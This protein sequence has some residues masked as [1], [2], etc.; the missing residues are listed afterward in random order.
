MPSRR[1][2][3]D[4]EAPSEDAYREASGEDENKGKGKG[5]HKRG[6]RRGGR[7]V[8]DRQFALQ[9]S[10]PP[11]IGSDSILVNRRA[12][13]AANLTTIAAGPTLSKVAAV[14]GKWR[15]VHRE[16][17]EHS[18]SERKQ[19]LRDWVHTYL[20]CRK[21]MGKIVVNALVAETRSVAG[22]GTPVFH[23]NVYCT[24]HMLC[25][26]RPCP[27][28]WEVHLD[29]SAVV[30]MRNIGD[31]TAD[32]AEF[33][34]HGSVQRMIS[35]LP[36]T[37]RQA[38]R[39]TGSQT[40]L[41][42]MADLCGSA[43]SAADA[44]EI[45]PISAIRRQR[46]LALQEGAADDTKVSESLRLWQ[47][48][49]ESIAFTRQKWESAEM[50]QLFSVPTGGERNVCL[51]TCKAFLEYVKFWTGSR[52]KGS[53]CIDCSWKMN[54]CEWPAVAIGCMG[55]HHDPKAGFRRATGLPASI[56]FGP[57]DRLLGS[58]VPVGRELSATMLPLTLLPPRENQ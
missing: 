55:Q 53:V 57:K 23:A 33:V 2:D 6:G 36:A 54:V 50:F 38:V 12:D 22:D 16:V 32:P 29:G 41:R 24:Q 20:K 21:E 37:Q 34:Q 45:P 40:P 15:E 8:C 18:F 47:Q 13:Q 43:K 7:T 26:D 17:L 51:L 25:D 56:A 9:A 58:R 27:V 1:S 28:R 46:R 48:Y 42:T 39:A 49:I 35:G 44:A 3:S 14:T 31:Q 30:V 11:P 10:S 4:Y 19:G 52:K 5:K